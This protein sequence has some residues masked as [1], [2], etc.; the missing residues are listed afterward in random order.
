MFLAA[1]ERASGEGPFECVL[2]LF[3]RIHRR[4][5]KLKLRAEPP[6]IVGAAAAQTGGGAR[7]RADPRVGFLA[8]A[9][10]VN[11]SLLDLS[12]GQGKVVSTFFVR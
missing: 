12:P 3:R 8:V 10:P 4:E 5:S 1:G 2:R 7:E 6:V 11:Q 9:A